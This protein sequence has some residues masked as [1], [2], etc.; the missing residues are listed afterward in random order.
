MTLALD[1]TLAART[2]DSGRLV[3]V[4]LSSATQTL[5]HLMIQISL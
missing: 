3:T 5:A 1:L 4:Y 2:A